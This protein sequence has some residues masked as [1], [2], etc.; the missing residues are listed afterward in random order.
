MTQVYINSFATDYGERT[1]GMVSSTVQQEQTVE[2]TKVLGLNDS[3]TTD[4]DITFLDLIKNA[5]DVF[6]PLQHIPVV[7][8]I[9]QKATGDE[10][11]DAAKLAGDTVYG[12]VVGGLVSLA[13][14]LY[15]NLIQ[16]DLFETSTTQTVATQSYTETSK[17]VNPKTVNAFSSYE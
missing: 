17:M 14:T 13:S 8:T 7:S 12:G 3:A 1:A 5:V 6:N 10:M 15:E 11:N 2:N 9:Y 16:G 4:E